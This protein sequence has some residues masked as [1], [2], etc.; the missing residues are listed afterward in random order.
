MGCGRGAAADRGGEDHL[1][2]RRADDEPRADAASRPR[3][4]R[5]L[6]A[7]RHRRRRRA[8]AGRPRQA[9]RRTASRAP[10]RRWATASPRP[11]RSAAAISGPIMPTSPPRPAGRTSRSSS[12]RSWARATAIC[13]PASAARSRSARPPISAAIGATRRRPRAAFTADGYFADRRHRLSR[14]GRLSVHRRPQEGHHHPRRRE[15][16]LPGGR[17]GDLRPSGGVGGLRCSACPTSGSAKCR[18]RWSIQRGGRRSTRRRLLAFLDERIAQ[19][20]DARRISGSTTSRCPS[21]AP[22]RSTRSTLARAL[23][24][25]RKRCRRGRT[26]KPALTLGASCPRPRPPLS[27]APWREAKDEGISRR[28]L[29]VGGGA[30]RRAAARLGLVAAHLSRPIFAPR[31]ARPC[32]TPS[33]R[34]AAT[35]GSS[36]PCRRPSSA[37]A[38]RPACRRSSPTSSA[39]TGAPSRSSRRRSARSTP[40]TCSPRSGAD[41]RPSVLPAA[42]AAGRRANMRPATR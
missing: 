4:I 35:A 29:L 13:R 23:S 42:S 34:S 33:S 19:L 8:A 20:Q 21:S 15:Y 28:T 10:S 32:S 1:F 27:A 31:R 6:V 37:R 26:E 25:T 24:A 30:G 11:T 16:Q 14:R 9:A 39:P 12:W 17:G 40:T 22:A 3:Q 38:S 5:S 2:R 7:D 18:R 41:E 36:S